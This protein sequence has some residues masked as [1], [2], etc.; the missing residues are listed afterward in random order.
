MECCIITKLGCSCGASSWVHVGGLNRCGSAGCRRPLC[1]HACVRVSVLFQTVIT[2][3][4]HAMRCTA[5]H[6]SRSR[7]T[8][9]T[10]YADVIPA[11]LTVQTLHRLLMVEICRKSNCTRQAPC[12]PAEWMLRHMLVSL[13]S[14]T[15]F[16]DFVPYCS[17]QP[18]TNTGL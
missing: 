17:L 3:N 15:Q 13:S 12:S 10:Y 5:L 16:C 4:P 9:S 14:S 1:V 8:Y 7:A 6:C 2:D 18:D 11:R